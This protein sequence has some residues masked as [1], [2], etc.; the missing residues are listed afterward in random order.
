MEGRLGG[1]DLASVKIAGGSLHPRA[2]TPSSVS[3][4]GAAGTGGGAGILVTF[5][6]TLRF[7]ELFT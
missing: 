4:T 7:Q 6:A 1:T 3:C 2:R 5:L